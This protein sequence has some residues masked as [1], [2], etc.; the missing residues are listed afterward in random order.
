LEPSDLVKLARLGQK[1][2]E[3]DLGLKLAPPQFEI[4]KQVNMTPRKALMK[5]MRPLLLVKMSKARRT[6]LISNC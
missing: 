1:T 5:P 4:R 2:P 3:K 6:N